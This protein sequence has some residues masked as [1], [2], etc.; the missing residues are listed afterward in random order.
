MAVLVGNLRVAIYDV[1]TR[2]PI[3]E[4]N[5]QHYIKVENHSAKSSS[6]FKYGDT[7]IRFLKNSNKLAIYMRNGGDFLILDLS[8]IDASDNAKLLHRMTLPE[9]LS[10]LE[11][12]PCSND[13]FICGV[14]SLELG[15]LKENKLTTIV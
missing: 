11:M 4:I 10:F 13:L 5:L 9:K 1:M 2:N 6:A 12:D 14:K 8:D 7:L 15:S 3:V